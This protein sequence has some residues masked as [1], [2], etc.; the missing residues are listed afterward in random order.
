MMKIS[1]IL[2]TDRVAFNINSCVRVRLTDKGRMLHAARHSLNWAG[3]GKA[4]PYSAPAE[5]SDGWSKWRLW[6]LMESFGRHVGLGTSPAFT[7][8]ELYTKDLTPVTATPPAEP[9]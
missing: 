5:D 8:I 6:E 2:A 4:S 1:E 9:T 3:H 7:E